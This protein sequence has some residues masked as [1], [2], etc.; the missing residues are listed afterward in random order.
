M[1][2]RDLNE[3]ERFF[4]PEPTTKLPTKL[5]VG[6][7]RLTDD[8]VIPTKAHVG[9]S[10]YDLVASEDIIVEPG[11][12]VVVKTGIA[13]QLPPGYE[14][15]VRPRSGVTSQTPI[16]VQVGTIDNGY[17]SEVGVIVD[18]T[19][20]LTYEIENYGHGPE[21]DVVHHNALYTIDKSG[22]VYEGSLL[23]DESV[24]VGTYIIRKGNKIAQLVI[25]KLP[26]LEA[27]E[28]TELDASERGDNGFGSS[29]VS[30]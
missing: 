3:I 2:K 11:E 22:T 4:N 1:T 12:T 16:R 24:P 15:T 13:V 17:T 20:Q 10:G 9:D 23:S 21:L 19:S 30:V 29:G 7:K 6:F 8:A 18:N 28:I 5:T 25:T 26:T 27:V 14:A